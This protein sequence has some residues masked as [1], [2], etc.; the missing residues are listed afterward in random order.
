MSRNNQPESVTS[1]GYQQVKVEDKQGL[2]GEV[3]HDVAGKYDIMNDFMSFGLHRIWKWLTCYLTDVQPGHRI[4]DLAGGTGDL[5]KILANK[6]GKDGK[7]ILSD[8]NGSML[9]E[10]RNKLIDNNYI[11]NIEYV[12]ANA[13]ALPFEDNSFDLV[14]MAFGLRNVTNKDKAL[15]S[16]YRV[17]KPGGKLFV[18]E[19][20]KPQSKLI[21]RAYD[22][23]SFN[24]I[25][26][27]GQWVTNK[28]EHYQY[29]VESIRVHPDQEKLK[30]MFLDAG[31]DSCTYNN[32]HSGV[33]ALHRG[34]KC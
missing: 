15:E 7:I 16:I 25:P 6:L 11:T 12:Q 3:F 4:L 9:A 13:E 10:G 31:F 29:L 28:S 2:V 20:S 23:Y 33:V 17:L 5:T 27:I 21:E 32:F 1:F 26:K 24:I 18:L 30:Q 14:T 19:F 34:Y 8:I 22:F